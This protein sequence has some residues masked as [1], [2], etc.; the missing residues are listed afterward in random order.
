LTRRN[1]LVT[2]AGRGIG[3][4]AAIRLAERGLDVALV[5]RSVDELEETRA[6]I[7][8]VGQKAAVLVCDVSKADDVDRAVAA[9]I[10][11]LG[12]PDVVVSAAGVVHRASVE[13]MT[14][15][16]WDEVLTVNLK[17]LFLVTRACLPA[18]R[19][20]GRGRFVAIASISSTLGTA[21]QSA[22]V[23]A[24]WGVVGFTKSLAEELRGS[25]LQTIAIMP[26]SVATSMLEGS[27]FAPQMTADDVARLVAYAALDAPDAMNGS[28]V[29][30]FGP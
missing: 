6:R 29:E 9:S 25:G 18:M 5:A 8:G 3:R 1:A 28:A 16:A 21:R 24:K 26:G 14:E 27:G 17:G 7:E 22:Y 4:A 10:R 12:S 23:A 2:G 19:N 13:E 30:M 15:Q 20:L 11:A